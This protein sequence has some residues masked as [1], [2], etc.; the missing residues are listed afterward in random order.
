MM[1]RVMKGAVAVLASAAIALGA[2]GCAGKPSKEAVVEG[3]LK[4]GE[5]YA[6][7]GISDEQKEKMK[8]YAEC[9]V[10]ETY[11]KLSADTLKKIADGNAN[12]D[13]KVAKEDEEAIQEAT[14]NC[15]SKLTGSN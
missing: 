12:K 13:T 15:A 3:W 14:K 4:F 9:L 11:D 10:D 1:S 8:P 6:S 5:N 2:A 7:E